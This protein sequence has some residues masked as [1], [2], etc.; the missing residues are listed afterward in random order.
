MKTKYA[1]GRHPHA[2]AAIRAAQ[3]THRWG[4]HAAARYAERKGVPAWLLRLACTLEW[5]RARA[6][7]ARLHAL[8]PRIGD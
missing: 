7:S 5:E 2:Q 1:P 4:P 8:D 6:H 3:N